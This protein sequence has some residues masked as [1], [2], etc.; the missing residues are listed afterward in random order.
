MMDLSHYVYLPL[1]KAEL[2]MVAYNTIVPSGK[3]KLSMED[4]MWVIE[5][6][7]PLVNSLGRTVKSDVTSI[8]SINGIDFICEIRRFES[9]ISQLASLDMIVRALEARKRENHLGYAFLEDTGISEQIRELGKV[10]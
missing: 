1:S 3:P 6:N 8:T 2:V 7:T 4:A 10:R 9:D 5:N